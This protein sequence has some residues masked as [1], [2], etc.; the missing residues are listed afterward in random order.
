M[1]KGSSEKLN[2]QIFVFEPPRTS[3]PL[4][5]LSVLSVSVSYYIMALALALGVI[6]AQ[7]W[8]E[9]D[10]VHYSSQEGKGGP[11]FLSEEGSW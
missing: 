1:P 9:Q 10:Q 11:C 3:H 7:D 5:L 8:E 4:L 2:L 6:L